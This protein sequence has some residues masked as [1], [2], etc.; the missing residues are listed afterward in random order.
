MTIGKKLFTSVGAIL[1]IALLLGGVGI[2]N[3]GSLGGD[4]DKL[5]HHYARA[6]YLTGVMNTIG[7]DGLA[8]T[9]GLLLS[10]HTN[11]LEAARRANVHYAEDVAAMTKNVTEFIQLT[12]KPEL[13]DIAQK[14]ILEK[15][16]FVGEGTTTMFGLVE[17]GDLT[18][19]DTLYWEKL[20]PVVA[21]IGVSGQHL[22]DLENEATTKYAEQA[23]GAVAP[24]RYL[25]LFMIVLALAAGAFVVYSI[26][27]I[28]TTLR[29]S[30]LDLTDGSN[31]VSSAA[32]QV[33]SSSQSLA[34]ETSEQAAMIEETSASAEEINSMARR[35][36]ESARKA[37]S[38]AVEAVKSTEQTNRAVTDCVQ[39][40]DAIG[41]SSNKI[42]KTLQ[43]IDK[44]AFQTNILALNA[45]VEAARAGEAGSGFAVV[46]EEVRNLAQRSATASEEISVMI[47][48]SQRNSDVGRATIGTLVES[49]ARINEV[50]LSMKVLVEE[51]SL[52]S[53]EQGNGIDQIGQAIQKME[54]GTQKSAANAEEGAA[55]AEQL[56]AQSEQLR[57]V[58]S[59]LGK[60]VGV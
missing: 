50:F 40:M 47:E 14:E 55:A 26:R 53:E 4:V 21:G 41:E 19:A 10:A 44:I 46:A 30:V 42:A 49:G 1:A 9:N 2:W 54:Q 58:A 33:A 43:V 13:K 20:M 52:G 22:S 28:N 23:V 7:A 6:V 3:V 45:A 16:Q 17:K 39:A 27:G 15:L 38:L 51:I 36:T 56:T 18:G 31:Q 48:Q 12:A 29:R 57:E 34:R 24:A 35:N 25:S 8:T 60:M 32:S 37:T 59:G 11:N 5:G